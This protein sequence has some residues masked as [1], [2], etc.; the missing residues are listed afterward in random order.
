MKCHILLVRNQLLGS[1]KESVISRLKYFLD[2]VFYIT[3][4]DI[5]LVPLDILSEKYFRL[6]LI[7]LYNKFIISVRGKDSDEVYGP[8]GTKKKDTDNIKVLAG[9]KEK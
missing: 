2:E 5:L 8:G 7:F 9:Q 6:P 1:L 4:N 3:S